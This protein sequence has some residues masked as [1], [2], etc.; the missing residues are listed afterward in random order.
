MV[1][2]SELSEAMEAASRVRAHR[3]QASLL[4]DLAIL[5]AREVTAAG[6]HSGID[7]LLSLPGVRAPKADLR[8]LL[9]AEP[10]GPPPASDSYGL[11]R[12]LEEQRDESQ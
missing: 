7:E 1:V 12:A 4:R 3:S 11:S 2:D 6:S 5:G 10:L 9:R 8:E